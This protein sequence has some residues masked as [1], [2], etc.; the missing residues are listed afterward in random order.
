MD[1][2]ALEVFR[3][4]AEQRSITKAAK[5]L[6]FVQSNVTAKIK[7]LE[8]DF[9]TQLFYRHSRGVTLTSAGI[10]LLSYTDKIFYLLDETRKAVQDTSIP[11]GSISIGSMETTAAVRLPVHLADYHRKFPLVD[12]KLK[13]GPTEQ[14]ID[15]VLHYQLDGAFVSG[16]VQHSELIQETIFK[17]ELVLVT[18]KY[19]ENYESVLFEMKNKNILVFRTGCSYR[20][21]LESWLREEGL[22]PI[23][24]M[25]FGTLEA[26]LGCVKS[27]FGISLLPRSVVSELESRGDLHI[28]S[29][30]DKFANVETVLIRRRDLYIN[31]ALEAFLNTVRQTEHLNI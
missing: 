29:I 6:N 1:I 22:F 28:H 25:E 27:G 19:G 7:Q 12:I 26:I 8:L 24:V 14:L 20:G 2:L 5:I 3:T 30:P 10:T 13:T 9:K 15:S 21:K 16:P 18:D 23:K 4:V 11:K 31:S 17:E